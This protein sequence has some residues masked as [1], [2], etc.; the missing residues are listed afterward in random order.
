[1]GIGVVGFFD[2]AIE[3][4]ENGDNQRLVAGLKDDVILTWID[5]AVVLQRG[6]AGHGK[7]KQARDDETERI[8]KQYARQTQDA[9]LSPGHKWIQGQSLN[10]RGAKVI[11]EG[12]V[13]CQTA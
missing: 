12:D 4:V 5:E 7:K 10:N 8:F 2:A 6:T 1:L 9:L 11:P 3:G 13:K